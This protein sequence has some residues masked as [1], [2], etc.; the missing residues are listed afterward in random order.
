[1]FSAVNHKTSS[2]WLLQDSG[3]RR[4]YGQAPRHDFRQSTSE[5]RRNA[6]DQLRPMEE[7]RELGNLFRIGSESW[8]REMGKYARPDAHLYDVCYQLDKT[9]RGGDL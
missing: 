4:H 8:F 9:E 6:R 2:I 7:Q 5:Q 3:Y 1:M